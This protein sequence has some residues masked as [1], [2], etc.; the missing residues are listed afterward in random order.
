MRHDD[1]DAVALPDPRDRPLQGLL[2]IGIEV[3]IGFVE[4][5]E[6]RAKWLADL[7]ELDAIADSAIL[8]VREE[9]SQDSVKTIDIGTLLEYEWRTDH[10]IGNV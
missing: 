6:E 9:V 4:N 2:A 7:E 8:L 3:G 10:W 5:D 1:N